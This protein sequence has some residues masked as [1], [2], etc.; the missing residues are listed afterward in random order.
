MAFP[1]RDGVFEFSQFRYIPYACV[2]A[3]FMRLGEFAVFYFPPKGRSADGE[4]LQDL[5]Q[6]DKAL[7]GQRDFVLGIHT[8]SVVFVYC[9][10]KNPCWNNT[11][12]SATEWA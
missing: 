2:G 5:L 7:S 8:S 10:I 11:G 3:E 9:E 12:Q 4:Y 6:A 1:L